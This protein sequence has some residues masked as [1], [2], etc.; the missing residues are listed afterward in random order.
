[1]VIVRTVYDDDD[2]MMMMVSGDDD[3]L[4]MMMI[5]RWWGD[6]EDVGFGD[7]YAVLLRVL[8]ML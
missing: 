1:M 4:K 2:Q 6:L 7:N 8:V 5:S 3:D